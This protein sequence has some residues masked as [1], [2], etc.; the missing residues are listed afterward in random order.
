MF[1][2]KCGRLPATRTVIV[3]IGISRNWLGVI[4]Q[5]LDYS[6]STYIFQYA[7][8]K[9]RKEVLEE[10]FVSSSVSAASQLD[11]QCQ[12]RHTDINVILQIPAGNTHSGQTGRVIL[13]LV[14][15]VGSHSFWSDRSGHTHS[16][17]TVT[18]N[19][20]LPINSLTTNDS[21]C[22]LGLSG[23]VAEAS[24][25]ACR[26]DTQVLYTNNSHWPKF[27]KIKAKMWWTI[28]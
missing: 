27:G 16:G 10:S 5:S 24:K 7:S 4:T 13:I 15:Q 12:H 23:W 8:D 26:Y 3:Q 21:I 11:Q 25:A 1:R 20:A 19:Q 18:G 2:K 17:Q 22:R 14:R 28:A 9:R 6:I